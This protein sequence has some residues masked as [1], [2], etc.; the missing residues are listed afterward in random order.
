MASNLRFG[1]KEEGYANLDEFFKS[2]MFQQIMDGDLNRNERDVLLVV[3]RK[4]IHYEKW[5]DRIAMYWLTKATGISES[6]LRA[7]LERLESKG[8]LDIKR[9]TGGKSKSAK[10]YNEF[11]LSTYLINSVYQ[12]WT[13]IKLENGFDIKYKF[14]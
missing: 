8:L 14:S 4:T 7:T 10:K 11:S 6:T 5:A 3:F 13:T 12:K 9:S 1:N 2:L